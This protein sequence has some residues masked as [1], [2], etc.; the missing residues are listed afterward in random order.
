MS[1]IIT[2]SK[3]NIYIKGTTVAIKAVYAFVQIG[4]KSFG[5]EEAALWQYASEEEML[6]AGTQISTTID[7]SAKTFDTSGAA[8][9]LELAENYWKT[10]LEKDSAYSVEIVK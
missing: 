9:S 3:T 5:T 8:P 2:P 6:K 4:S 1:L 10:A 7:G